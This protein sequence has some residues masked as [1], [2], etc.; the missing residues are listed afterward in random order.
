MIFLKFFFQ[1]QKN[2]KYILKLY[3][4]LLTDRRFAIVLGVLV[5]IYWYF[6]IV[7]ALRIE[8]KLDTKKILPKDSPLQRP[9]E[10][11]GGVSEF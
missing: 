7:G 2:K 10:L 9:N 4:R 11:L 3:C 8:T 5:V 1:M 6:A